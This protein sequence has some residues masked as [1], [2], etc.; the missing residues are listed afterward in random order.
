MP[1]YLFFIEHRPFS[2]HREPLVTPE[3][4]VR[5]RYAENERE[6]WTRVIHVVR[7]DRQERRE[8][9]PNEDEKE[10]ADC[11][12][13][14]NESPSAKSKGSPSWYLSAYLCDEERRD[15]LEIGHVEGEVVEG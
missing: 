3:K 4:P 6:D 2:R 13:V 12:G 11:E 8:W 14:D 9:Q 1:P 7:G 15:D 10:E 5:Q